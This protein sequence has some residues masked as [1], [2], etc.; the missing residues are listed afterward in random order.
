[1]KAVYNSKCPVCQQMVTAGEIIEPY[2]NPETGYVSYVHEYCHPNYKKQYPSFKPR[3]LDLKT[4]KEI[5]EK[6]K[7]DLTE[8][9]KEEI[10]EEERQR[11]AIPEGGI[12]G[13]TVDPPFAPS[14]QR[15]IE[16]THIHV[17]IE[18]ITKL[19]KRISEIEQLMNN[20]YLTL[21]KVVD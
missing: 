12:G 14:P 8:Q 10:G 18:D 4:A 15:I 6:R 20:L 11:S 2:K 19:E 9:E 17:R 16:T 5:H 13:E 1:M 21:K 7:V 3:P